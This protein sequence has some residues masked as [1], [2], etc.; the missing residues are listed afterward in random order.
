[1][2]LAAFLFFIAITLSACTTKGRPPGAISSDE[3]KAESVYLTHDHEGRPVAVWTER[4]EKDLDLYFSASSDDGKSFSEKIVVPMSGDV[5]THAEGM[6]KVAFKKD[7]TI[8]A[9]YEKSAPTPDNKY[10]G[11]IYYVQSSDG[12][13]SWSKEQFLHS[14]TL[15]GR[16][17]S[18]FDLE[19]LPDGEIG[20]SWLDI[21][22]DHTTGGRSVRFAKTSAAQGFGNEILIDSSACQCCRIDVY[23]DITG[24]VN[25][26]YRGLIKG[27]MGRSIRDMM[28]V[29]SADNGESFS[30][31][32]RISEDNWAIEGC[33]H[34]GPSL[35]SSNAGLYSLWYTE[36]NGIGI[37][38]SF[39]PSGDSFGQR[40]LVSNSGHHPQLSA[41]DARSIMVWE[42]NPDNKRNTFIRYRLTNDGNLITGDIGAHEDGSAFLPVVTQTQS[43]FV[44]AYLMETGDHVAVYTLQL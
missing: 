41:S 35:C 23:S 7:G 40:E 36:G 43:G 17:R 5:A 31:P 13:K 8:V 37:Y 6:P 33:P 32:L 19:R 21:K 4:L 30:T 26:A 22:L 28:L 14:D 25:I 18:Y 29:T 24:K 15:A 39:R 42:E 44:V 3:A 12:G 34:T 20:A 10:A 2:R 11:A 38:S 1:M 16:S 27:V 9:A